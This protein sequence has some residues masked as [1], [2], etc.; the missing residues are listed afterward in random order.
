MIECFADEAEH[1]RNFAGAIV[2]PGPVYRAI[3]EPDGSTLAPP[4]PTSVFAA[5]HLDRS[6]PQRSK[7]GLA[8]DQHGVKV[9]TR[10]APIKIGSTR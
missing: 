3:P 5:A 2:G 7:T 10:T 1:G 6:F 8:T 4:P 9:L